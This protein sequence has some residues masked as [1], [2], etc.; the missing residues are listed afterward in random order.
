MNFPDAC[1][2]AKKQYISE[3]KAEIQY[4]V[5]EARTKLSNEELCQEL[6]SILREFFMAR[7]MPR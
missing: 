5:K 3:L 2:T 4:L 1:S 7:I 6:E